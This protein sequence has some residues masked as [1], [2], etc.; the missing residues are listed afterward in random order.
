VICVYE[1]RSEVSARLFDVLLIAVVRAWFNR[2]GNAPTWW[3]AGRDPIVGPALK[4]IYNNPA[5]PWTVADL[6]AA[7]GYSRA[8][9]APRFTGQVGEPPIAFL[10]NWQLALAADLLR[11]SHADDRRGCPAGR[12]QHTVRF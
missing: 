7:V 6:A 9:F 11:S 8:V 1:G 4:L 2:D 3:Q 10:T 12:L 5:Y